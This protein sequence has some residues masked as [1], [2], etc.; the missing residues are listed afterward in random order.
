MGICINTHMEDGLM[1]KCEKCSKEHNGDYGSGRFCSQQCAIS[2]SSSK[3]IGT[4]KVNCIECGTELYV[5]KRASSKVCK[6]DNCRKQKKFKGLIYCLHCNKLIPKRKRA[7]F[8]SQ[9]CKNTYTRNL[10]ITEWKNGNISGNDI[11]GTLSS[12]VRRYIFDKYNSKCQKCGWSEIHSLTGKIPL[13]INHID[14]NYLNS[15][16]ENLE[17]MCPNCHSLTP[18]YGSL[19]R[20][21]GRKNRKR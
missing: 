13:Q 9:K 3:C 7:K 20:G 5:D 21:F 2:F 10:Y 1:K 17:L 12:I 11:G 18:N 4:K 14:G 16:E 15:K 19:N 8:C 6:C